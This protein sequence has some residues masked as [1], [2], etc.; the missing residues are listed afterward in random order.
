MIINRD[1]TVFRGTRNFEPS[2]RI[3]PFS[4]WNTWLPL[5]LWREEY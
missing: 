3:C 5:G 1:T 2:R 4:P